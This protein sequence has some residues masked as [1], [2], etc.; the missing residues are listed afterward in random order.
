MNGALII[1]IAIA[2]VMGLVSVLLLNDP[3]QEC[4]KTF[5]IPLVVSGSVATMPGSGDPTP[6]VLSGIYLS[7]ALFRA[8]DDSKDFEIPVIF[9]SI[10]FIIGTF[11]EPG[12][13]AQ[14]TGAATVL[15]AL[16]APKR[17]ETSVFDAVYPLKATNFNAVYPLKAAFDNP[18][19]DIRESEAFRFP[20]DFSNA[21]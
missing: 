9:I 4:L 12:I 15:F 10:M 1:G 2:V 17:F 3:I 11:A 13:V 8:I 14:I 20:R 6:G 18:V 21:R 16:Y 7:I 19:F 5:L